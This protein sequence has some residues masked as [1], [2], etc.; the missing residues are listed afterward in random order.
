MRCKTTIRVEQYQFIDNLRHIIVPK[1]LGDNYENKIEDVKQAFLKNGW[2]GDGE[3]GLIW[4]PPFIEDNGDTFGEYVWHVK[5]NNNGISFLGYEEFEICNNEDFRLIKEIKE[6]KF[7]ITS[8]VTKG[9]LDNI[10]KYRINLE[11]LK[12]LKQNNE[13]QESLYHITLNAIQNN[14]VASFID[15]IDELYLCFLCHVI[16]EKNTD[17]LKLSKASVK[18]PLDEISKDENRYFDSWLLIKQVE[19][20]TWRDFKFRPFKEKFKE[21]CNIVDF[22][23]PERTRK[24]IVNHVEIR[25]SIQHHD[26][27][28]NSEM[29][30]MI[31]QDYLEIMDEEGRDNRIELWNSIVLSIP[32]VNDF[33]ECLE[34][35]INEYEQYISVRMKARVMGYKCNNMVL[36]ENKNISNDYITENRKMEIVSYVYYLQYTEE[37]DDIIV[38]TKDADF[39]VYESSTFKVNGE[40]CTSEEFYELLLS[41]GKVAMCNGY[42][43]EYDGSKFLSK[44]HI[45]IKEVRI[46]NII[47]L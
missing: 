34:G 1:E 25:N 14:I 38:K 17:R 32:E 43:F 37:I 4:I 22:K 27:Q 31:G 5:Q 46:S 15:Y 7:T 23:C 16:D 30:K 44:E 39:Y 40:E 45:P 11:E 12:C 8:D 36:A 42:E 28:F 18:L 41:Q 21:I 26:G 35:F 20:A 9:C 19:S 33:C 6:E 3:I 47:Q 24:K 2:E 13:Y 29:I 10:N